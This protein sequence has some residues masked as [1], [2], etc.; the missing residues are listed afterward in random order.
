MTDADE[1][2]FATT[3]DGWRLALYRYRP[4]GAGSG[5]PVL[6]CSG[7]GCNRHFIDYDEPYSLARFLARQGFEAWPVELRGRGLSRP[8]R[9]C[10]R[11]GA[12][13]FDDLARQDVPTMLAYV[14]ETTGRP[15]AWVGHSMG[16]LVLYACLGTRPDVA[17]LV[18]AGV[19]VGS[20]VRFPVMHRSLAARVGQ[21]V[22]HVPIGDMVPQRLIIGVLWHLVGTS[23][24][25]LG[26]NPGN[27]DRHAVGQAL[28]RAMSDVSRH[29]L[30]QLARWALE[31][32]FAS[33][34]RA[35]DYRTALANVTT[36]LLVT[37]G[38][39]DQIATPDAVRLALEHLPRGVGEYAEFG[40]A[41][42]HGVD[43]GHVDLI[44]GRA[45]PIE[46][47]PAI[48]RWLAEHAA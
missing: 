10:L 38:S 37:A 6:L 36:P 28:R 24:L 41:H 20:P 17:A 1:I 31:G 25:A 7:Y 13:T 22:L 29:K 43:F 19:T 23:N 39:G 4:R 48:G 42:G 11:P 12:W 21:V 35:I 15:V 34:D 47:F 30:Q 16:G 3:P 18:A 5:M 9:T 2:H 32:D 46:V 45:A 8:T 26:M 40:R 33:A 27:I 14:A 44:L